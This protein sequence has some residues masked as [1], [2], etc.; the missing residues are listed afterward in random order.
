MERERS[1][2]EHAPDVMFFASS[3]AVGMTRFSVD[4]KVDDGAL[5]ADDGASSAGTSESG[6]D[7][8]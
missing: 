4:S 3:L 7:S 5:L 1:R 8:F 2:A 6:C